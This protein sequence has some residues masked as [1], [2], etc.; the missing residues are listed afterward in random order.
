MS[1]LCV[2]LSAK[3]LPGP[4][5]EVLLCTETDSFPVPVQNVGVTL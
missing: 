4:V 1:N 5:K 2:E 3:Q